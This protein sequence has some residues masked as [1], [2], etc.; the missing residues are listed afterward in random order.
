MIYFRKDGCWRINCDFQADGYA[1]SVESGLPFPWMV[2]EWKLWFDE[3]W[4]KEED[5]KIEPFHFPEYFMLSS[6][7][8]DGKK[9]VGKYEKTKRMSKGI[10]IYKRK[11][12]MKLYFQNN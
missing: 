5:F 12:S 10:P 4:N 3:G 7:T 11:D 8:D 6:G 9:I 1:Y 2:K